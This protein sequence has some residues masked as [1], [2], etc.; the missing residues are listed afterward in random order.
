MRS[1]D[2]YQAVAQG[3]IVSIKPHGNSMTPYIRSGDPIIIEPVAPQDVKRGDIVLV[4]VKG[5]IFLH[6]VKA[7]TADQVLIANAHGHLNG[8][9]P[10]EKVVGVVT[11]IRDVPRAR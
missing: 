1:S 2:A 6:F 7:A 3:R 11:Q 8:W 9:T 10:R 5:R 4:K